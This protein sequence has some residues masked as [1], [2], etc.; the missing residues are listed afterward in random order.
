MVYGGEARTLPKQAMNKI[1]FSE[2]KFLDRYMDLSIHKRSGKSGNMNS[3]MRC[4]RTY[5]LI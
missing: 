2:T 1:D 5:I 4:I 3:Y